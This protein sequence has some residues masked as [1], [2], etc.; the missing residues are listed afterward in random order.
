MR[1]KIFEVTFTFSSS[2]KNHLKNITDILKAIGNQH[3]ITKIKQQMV[4]NFLGIKLKPQP[5][6]ILLDYL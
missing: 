5:P 1:L 2:P 6:L 3:F 4:N